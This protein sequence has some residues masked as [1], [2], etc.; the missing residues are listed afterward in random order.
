M[1]THQTTN[2]TGQAT[3]QAGLAHLRRLHD[4]YTAS[5][6]AA[7]AAHRAGTLTSTHVAALVTA[8]AVLDAAVE[9][10]RQAHHPRVPVLLAMSGGLVTPGLTGPRIVADWPQTGQDVRA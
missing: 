10:H 4:A 9:A 5:V 8:G 1:R 2:P 7:G 3:E 6:A